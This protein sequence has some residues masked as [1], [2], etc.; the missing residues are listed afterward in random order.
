MELL[1]FENGLDDDAIAQALSITPRQ[2]V[3]QVC[4][5]LEKSGLLL[6]KQGLAGKIV[7]ELIVGAAPAAGHCSQAFTPA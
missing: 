6:R 2:T 1:A 5:R 7:N 4:R 3:N